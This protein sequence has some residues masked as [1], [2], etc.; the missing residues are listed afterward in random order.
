[1]LLLFVRFCCIQKIMHLLRHLGPQVLNSACRFD[2]II[3]NLMDDYHDLRLCLPVPIAFQDIPSNLPSLTTEHMMKLALE[4]VRGLSNDGG[5][6]LF[7]MT[8]VAIPPSMLLIFAI[9]AS[10]LLRVPLGLSYNLNLPS[11]QCKLHIHPPLLKP[12]MVLPHI[13]LFQESEV[14]SRNLM[15]GEYLK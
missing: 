8:D 11:K 3:D 6:D 15:S 14:A 7:A 1:M 12:D 9:S 10:F 13:D 2:S 5:L 4:Q